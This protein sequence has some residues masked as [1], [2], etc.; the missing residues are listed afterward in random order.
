MSANKNRMWKENWEQSRAKQCFA[1]DCEIRSPLYS[2]YVGALP[3]S[4]LYFFSGLEAKKKSKASLVLL[5]RNGCRLDENL[6]ESLAFLILKSTNDFVYP[7]RFGCFAGYFFV[8]LETFLPKY[9]ALN[10]SDHTIL[11]SPIVKGYEQKWESNLGIAHNS[12]VTYS[13]SSVHI[14]RLPLLIFG[15]KVLNPKKGPFSEELLCN[16]KPINREYRLWRIFL[17]YTL[18]DIEN[19]VRD[20][21]YK[22]LVVYPTDYI[23]R[24]N[25]KPLFENWSHMTRLN[26]ENSLDRDR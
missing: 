24:M 20:L 9:Y 8:R 7:L 17:Y 23:A 10:T 16:R 12:P 6:L 21:F 25:V 22:T 13:A 4:C 11:S 3:N 26:T 14:W 19:I 1:F 15:T 2:A 5:L 18:S